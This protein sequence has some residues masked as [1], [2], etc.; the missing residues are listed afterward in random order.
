MSRFYRVG[1]LVINLDAFELVS[2][3]NNRLELLSR[4]RE[5]DKSR[6][7]PDVVIPFDSQVAASRELDKITEVTS[8]GKPS[9]VTERL[10]IVHCLAAVI[11]AIAQLNQVLL[12]WSIIAVTTTTAM[13][14]VTFW[15]HTHRIDHVYLPE[16]NSSP[17]E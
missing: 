10:V 16:V 11:L 3:T 1:G 7:I 9:V 8:V 17:N 5:P 4:S 6:T 13:P 15:L 14:L 2:L 12:G